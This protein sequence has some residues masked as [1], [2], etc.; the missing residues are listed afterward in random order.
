VTGPEPAAQVADF[1]WA[2]P[3]A[4][5]ELD[6][7]PATRAQSIANIVDER[8]AAGQALGLARHQLADMLESIAAQAKSQE[9]RG[10]HAAL[11]GF[12]HGR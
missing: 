9:A 10:G 8:G 3:L 1:R 6:L 12:V 11:P 2:L 5:V 7:N 4:W